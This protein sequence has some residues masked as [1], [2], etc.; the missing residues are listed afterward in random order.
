MGHYLRPRS[1]DE[2]ISALQDRPRTII[3]GGTDHFPARVQRVP[4]ED[5]LDITAIAGLSGIAQ[6]GPFWRIG[7]ATT[8]TQVIEADLPPLFDGLKR[9]AREVGGVQIQNAGTVAGNVCNASPAADGIPP[10]MALNAWVELRNAEGMQRM[11]V[12]DFV[13]GNRQTSRGPRDLLT[14]LL[15]PRPHRDTRSHFLKLGA[16][17]YLVISIAMVAVTIEIEAGR[18]AQAA[19]VV[20]ACGPVARHLRSLEA[21]L[22]GRACDGSLGDCVDA[23]DMLP[24]MPIDDMRATAA[25]RRDAAL[26]T[27]RRALAETGAAP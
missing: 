25:Y 8:W 6:N 22:Q 17:R 16:R 1:V 7:A 5:I 23:A 15:V 3:A 9:A 10:L 18:I 14:A 19:V 21:K 2:A 27:V 11:P 4:E 13:L 24:L 26:T 12:R 20:G